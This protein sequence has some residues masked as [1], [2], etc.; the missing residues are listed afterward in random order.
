MMKRT[1]VSRV[2]PYLVLV[3]VVKLVFGQ[4]VSERRDGD[5]AD[6]THFSERR[7]DLL[8]EQPREEVVL[9][10][11]LREAVLARVVCSNRTEI[12]V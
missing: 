9:A 11:L 3:A 2:P 1:V 5:L 6:R 12:T 8:Q 4:Q 10:E 7:P